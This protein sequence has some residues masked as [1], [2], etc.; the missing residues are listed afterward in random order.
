M[1]ART[2]CVDP[3]AAESRSVDYRNDMLVSPTVISLM[4]RFRFISLCLDQYTVILIMVKT[5][6]HNVVGMFRL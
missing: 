4:S 5:L 2:V 1:E 6:N 3:S